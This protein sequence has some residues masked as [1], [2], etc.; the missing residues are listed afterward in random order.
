MGNQPLAFPQPPYQTPLTDKSGFLTPAWNKWLQQ[1]YLRV[2]GSTS[3]PIQ[4][5]NSLPLV[6]LVSATAPNTVGILYTS[7]IGQKSVLN[8]F[9]IQNVDVV[10]RTVSVWLVPQGST[11]GS[12][13]IAVNALSIPAK[14]IVTVSTLQFQVINGGG[15]IQVQGSVPG[16]LNVLATGRLSS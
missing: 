12:G 10:A 9:T 8:S 16:L 11:P 4:N 2:G 6:N 13:N 15:T 14:S 5:V 3:A 7:P 1:L